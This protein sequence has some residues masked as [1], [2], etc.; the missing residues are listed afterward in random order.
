MFEGILW[1]IERGDLE[2]TIVLVVMGVPG[3]LKEVKM[4]LGY[5]EN[6]SF[7]RGRREGGMDA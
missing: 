3:S 7:H 5:D 4:G 1:V 6:H 2:R